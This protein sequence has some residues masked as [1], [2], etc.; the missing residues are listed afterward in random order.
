MTDSTTITSNKKQKSR[1]EEALFKYRQCF[2]EDSY[3]KDH[4]DRFIKQLSRAEENTQDK[5]LWNKFKDIITNHKRQH[6]NEITYFK[7]KYIKELLG[8]MP[9]MVF[10]YGGKNIGK[11]TALSDLVNEVFQEHDKNKV[12]YLR[13]AKEHLDKGFRVQNQDE[14][15]PWIW[16]PT[17]GELTL[18][19]GHWLH[20]IGKRKKNDLLGW[21]TYLT[22]EGTRSFQGSV[23]EGLKYLIWDECNDTGGGSM[24]QRLLDAFLIFAVSLERNNPDFKIVMTGNLLTK[25]GGSVENEILDLLNIPL[26]TNLRYVEIE[27]ELFPEKKFTFLYI[28]TGL[29]GELFEGS[30]TQK[31]NALFQLTMKEGL[32]DNKPKDISHAVINVSEFLRGDPYFSFLIF[33]DDIHWIIYICTKSIGKAEFKKVYWMISIEEYDPNYHIPGYTPCSD[34]I[35]ITSAFSKVMPIDTMRM[36]NMYLRMQRMFTSRS[37]FYANSNSRHT[38]QKVVWPHIRA[39]YRHK[40]KNII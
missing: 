2:Y 39:K 31:F 34:D 33:V 11:T 17:N 5:E 37:V 28:N 23:Y 1:F 24:N 26:E 18:K 9:S 10:V 22:G 14:I 16:S 36:V 25:Q 3:I 4:I 40:T 21:A 6:K 7:F 35:L 27:N 8:F 32:I 30:K 15:W 38:F 29:P 20:K 19:T 13:T 12:F